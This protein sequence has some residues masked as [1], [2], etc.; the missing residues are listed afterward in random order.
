MA[1]DS[2][3]KEQQAAEFIERYRAQKDLETMNEN[4]A[5]PHQKLKGLLTHL[6]IKSSLYRTQPAKTYLNPTW[7]WWRKMWPFHVRN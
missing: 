4:V 2:K 6:I 5:I 1:E 3:V 7:N